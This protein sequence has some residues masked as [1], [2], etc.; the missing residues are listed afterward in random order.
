MPFRKSADPKCERI[1]LKVTPTEKATI[2][3]EASSRHLTVSEF[4]LR[5]MLGKQ[6]P[7][8]Y[9]FEAINTLEKMALELKEHYRACNGRDEDYLQAFMDRLVLVS[10]AIWRSASPP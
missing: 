3:A 1:A 8:R 10:D 9:N 6:A 4:A 2:E 5:R 7:V